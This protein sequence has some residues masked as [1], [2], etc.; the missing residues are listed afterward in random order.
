MTKKDEKLQEQVFSC[1]QKI[2]HH[3]YFPEE[4]DYVYDSISEAKERKRGVNPMSQ[5]YTDKTN[6]R[7]NQLGVSALDSAGEAQDDSSIS[8]ASEVAEKQVYKAN[9][10]LVNYL[11]QALY[12]IDP[13]NTQCKEKNC[14]DEYEFI[15]RS[16]VDAE[17]DGEPFSVALQEQMTNS[18]G[19]ETFDYR[20][21]NTLSEVVIETIAGIISINKK[22]ED[23]LMKME[24]LCNTQHNTING[25]RGSTIY[26]EQ[27]HQQLDKFGYKGDRP[28]RRFGPHP[29]RWVK[30]P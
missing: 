7:R 29:M 22:V 15:A 16:V 28:P 27:L 10:K 26:Y 18:F 19:C 9:K 6:A 13:A 4:Y 17:Q 1:V 14:Y 25:I 3:Y 23:V 5:E 24:Q 8:F 20:T 30:R 2:L 21:I 12:E 11:S